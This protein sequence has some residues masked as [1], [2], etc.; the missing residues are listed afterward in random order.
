MEYEVDPGP[1]DW[2][3]EL[4]HEAGSVRQ[5]ATMNGMEYLPLS[6]RELYYWSQCTGQD[7]NPFWMRELM[8][9]SGILAKQITDSFQIECQAPFDPG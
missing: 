9:L 2:L 7:L 1:L 5:E 8:K 4:L 6:W 3:L